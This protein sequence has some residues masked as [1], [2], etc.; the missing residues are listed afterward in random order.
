MKRKVMLAVAASVVALMPVMAQAANKLIVKDATGTTDK[1]VVTDQ[2]YVG[3]GTNAPIAA[4]VGEGPSYN[5]S[6]VITRFTATASNGGGGFL[7]LHNNANGALPSLNDRLG[8]F[9]FGSLDGTTQRNAAGIAAYA[10]G[11]W[12]GGATP[13][14][15]ASITFETANTTGVRTERMRVTYYGYIGIGTISPQQ[16]LDVNGAIKTT[17]T[18]A[19]PTCNAT[20]R[21]TFWFYKNDTAGTSPDTLDVCAKDNTGTYVWKN[22]F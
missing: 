10:A 3:S 16:K 6:Q 14:T 22:I 20:I 19:K 17:N 12:V 5:A 8:Y 2:G 4:F 1:F 13:S 21:G 18:T 7:G 15:P 9:Y 11:P